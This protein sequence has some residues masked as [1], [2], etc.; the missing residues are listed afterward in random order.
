VR[1]ERFGFTR[2]DEDPGRELVFGLAGR[3]WRLDGDLRRMPDRAAF[4]AFVEQGCVKAAWNLAIGDESEAG[5]ELTT[6]TR[7]VCFGPVARRRFRTYWFFVRPF[8]GLLRRALLRGV[9]R[10]AAGRR[11]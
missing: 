11:G 9:K 6:E 1:V 3:F 8:S 10:R 2:L 7:I 4:E 5:C